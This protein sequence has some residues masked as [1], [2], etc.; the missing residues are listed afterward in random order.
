MNKSEVVSTNFYGINHVL[1]VD[2]VGT[3]HGIAYLITSALRGG[4]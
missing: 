2:D 1:Y 3:Q 4:A